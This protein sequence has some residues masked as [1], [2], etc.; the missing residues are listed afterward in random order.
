MF[1]FGRWDDPDGALQEYFARA[2]ELQ[3]NGIPA[4]RVL[5]SEGLV[6]DSQLCARGH[7]VE[8]GDGGAIIESTRTKLSRT[9]AQIR[10]GLALLGR[11][12]HEVLSDILGYDDDR[13]TE[14]VI[15]GVLE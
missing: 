13:I 10:D 15:A 5:D 8:R 12:S 14:L 11:D 7:F 2:A 9:P 4:H 6:T 1:Y 3:R